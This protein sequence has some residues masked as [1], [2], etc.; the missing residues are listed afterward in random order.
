MVEPRPPRDHRVVVVGAGMGG[1]VSAL[2]LAQRGLQ[3][4]LVEAA[5]A[6]GGKMRQL[7]VDGALIDG[8]PTVFTMRWVF[9]EILAQ[10]GSSL[11]ALVGLQP[12]SVLARHAWRG[13]NP[14]SPHT[15]DLH[16]DLRASAD[17]IAQFSSPAEARRYLSFCAEARRVY[18]R[19][20]APYIRSARPGVLRMVRELGPGGLTALA[21]L[22]PFAT[23]WTRLGHHFRDPRMRQLFGRYATYCGASPWLA[24]ATLMLIAHVEQ[25]GVWSVRGGM[26]ALPQALAALARERGASL[27]FGQGV[28]RI[29][30]RDGRACGVRLADGHELQADSVVFNGDASALAQGLLGG[31]VAHATKATAP[32]QRS[33]SALTWAVHARCSG[34]AL[35]R[36]NVFFCDDYRREFD[37]VL[38]RRRLP[39]QGTV[40]VCAQDRADDA[41]SPPGRERLLC[42]VNAPAE[43]DRRSFET[44]EIEPCLDRSRK[45]LHHCGL[46]L[47]AAAPQVVTTPAQFHRLFPGT[48]GALYGAAS[49][50]WTAVFRRSGSSSRLPGLYLAGGSVHPG[51]GVP[52]AALSGRLA[53]ETLLAHLD[54]TSRSRPVVTYGGTST[55]SATTAGTG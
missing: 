33:L 27:H 23:L 12:L 35:A 7:A 36:H 34:F 20:E 31:D 22:G 15:L 18:E 53:A 55:P 51:P 19:L 5:A 24:P 41:E 38:R 6:P 43:G 10:A 11:E 50:G 30:V 14:G 13:E 44:S 49:H 42:L 39:Q 45:L 3:V 54:S 46:Q 52:M 48:G 16:A 4:T 25:S 32:A 8:G 29:L 2:L 9:D 40:Y 17:A 21:G 37:D 26:H 47:E 1:L 28:D